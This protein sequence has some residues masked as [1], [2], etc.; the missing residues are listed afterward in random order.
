MENQNKNIDILGLLDIENQLK[1]EINETKNEIEEGNMFDVLDKEINWNNIENNSIDILNEIKNI[2][3]E[4]SN[5]VSEIINEEKKETFLQKVKALSIFLVKY[6][7][8]SSLIFFIL[9]SITNYSAYIEIARSYL[10]PETFEKNKME[11]LS[12]VANSTIKENKKEKKLSTQEK[13]ILTKNK[14]YH[15]MD[16]LL[17]WNY[18][19]DLNLQVDIMPF[20]NRIVI[21]KI[22]KN[23]PLLEVQNKPV[24]NVKELEDVF[25]K[26]LENW[27]IRYPW[28]AQPWK[29]WNSFIFWHS[30]N[31]PWIK[32]EYNDVF[33]LLDNVSYNDE[34]IVYYDQKKYVYKIK[35]KKIINP[36]DISILKRNKWKKELSL[37]TCWPIWTTINR[38]IVIWELVDNK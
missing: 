35:E 16:K 31:F 26:D 33:A 12:S 13:I 3:D 24:S 25:M 23:I 15:S 34:I 1:P 32:W 14:T 38:L 37:M 2:D 6:I 10:S 21:P 5:I 11:I 18:D 22:W 19:E 27:V 30:S 9:L 8:T 29:D 7:T 17:K 36:W 4:N 28:S 20:E